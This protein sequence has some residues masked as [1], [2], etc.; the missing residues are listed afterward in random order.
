MTNSPVEH[1]CVLGVDLGGTRIA[2]GI[3]DPSGRIIDRLETPSP[4]DDGGRMTE[5]LVDIVSRG[6]ELAEASGSRA[7]ASGLGVAGFIIH[8]E[9]FLLESPNIAWVDVPL[10]KIVAER[11]G[12]ETFLD[13]DANAA[14]LGERLA[15]VAQGVD[16]FVY[17]TLG[18][19]IG[20]GICIG[21]TVYRGNRGTAAELGH[22]SIDPS[23]PECGCGRRGCLEAL[24]SGTALERAAAEAAR[25]DPD[26][27]LNR[28]CDDDPAGI[29]G[30]IVS[31]AAE[32]GD[33][34]ALDAFSQIAYYLGLGIVNLIHIFDPEMV[35]LGGGVSH[36]GHLLLDEVRSVVRERGIR[37]LVRDARIELSSLGREAGVVGAGAIAWEGMGR[38]P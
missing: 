36:S 20:G 35:V 2:L 21:G 23:G 25:E 5:A 24:A 28:L 1:E 22:M 27:L 34:A 16:D 13:N 19:G 9:G 31:R 3:V 18:T 12:L 6:R 33:R 26:S 15:G 7:V 11:T 8:D 38:Q 4:A 10:R 32:A 17:L 37:V 14:C 30:E 29:T